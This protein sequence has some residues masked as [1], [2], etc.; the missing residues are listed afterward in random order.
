[1]THEMTT[2]ETTTGM[3]LSPVSGPSQ[4]GRTNRRRTSG[5][6]PAGECGLMANAYPARVEST[7]IV[8]KDS[9]ILHNDRVRLALTH[10]GGHMAPVTFG[11][12]NGSVFEPYYVSPWGADDL[13]APHDEPCVKF[14]RGDFFCLPFGNPGARG[15][16]R[17][18]LHGETSFAPWRF[19]G[20][21]SAGA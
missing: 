8:G 14:I 1:M 3:R 4:S 10:D 16:E 12:P 5:M 15:A 7:R 18:L 20:S 21:R 9:W 2:D 11:F 6:R 19:A 13:P 17:N